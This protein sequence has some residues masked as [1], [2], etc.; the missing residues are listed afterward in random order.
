[1]IDLAGILGLVDDFGGISCGFGQHP[2]EY[3]D[4]YSPAREAVIA[5]LTTIIEERDQ[6]IKDRDAAWS[7]V[8]SMDALVIERDQAVRDSK[9]DTYRLIACTKELA[10]VWADRDALA[11]RVRELEGAIRANWQQHGFREERPAYSCRFCNAW[12]F[13]NEQLEHFDCIVRTI[14]ESK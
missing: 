14:K 7:G 1:M 6:A 12:S 11:L 9:E 2:D 13:I 4:R 10:K 3:E 5:A 8:K